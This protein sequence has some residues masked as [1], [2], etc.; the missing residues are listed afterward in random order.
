M[1]R[2]EEVDN[3]DDSW[4][5]AKKRVWGAL[6]SQQQSYKQV[7]PFAYIGWFEE[8][9]DY[10]FERVDLISIFFRQCTRDST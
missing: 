2:F 3:L 8:G 7:L 9:A 10:L 5:L 6:G 4:Y 1:G